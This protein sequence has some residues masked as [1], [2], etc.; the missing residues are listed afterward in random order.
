MTSAD[1]I[2]EAELN[3]YVD[4]QLDIAGRI[5]VEEH[6]A[7][8]PDVAA[9]VMAD[10]HLRDTLRFAFPAKR[11]EAAEQTLA[12]ARKL[13]K[14]LAFRRTNR[15]IQ[16][17]AAGIAI[18]ALGWSAHFGWNELRRPPNQ[19]QLLAQAALLGEALNVRLPRIPE[20]WYVLK[21]TRAETPEGPGVQLTFQTP[22]FGR[23]SLVA[24]N[25]SDVGFVLPTI[26]AENASNIHWQLVSDRYDLTAPLGRKPLEFAALELYQ[27]LY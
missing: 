17:L 8:H 21:A 24:R 7:R 15:T 3:A 1:R 5:E 25:T 12:W 26:E 14:A 4:G 22:E 23:L 20:G 13:E 11:T 6:L 9:R 18:F 27:T 19:D 16:R 10:L 2:S